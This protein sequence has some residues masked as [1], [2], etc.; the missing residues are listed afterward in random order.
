MHALLEL[1][2]QTSLVLFYSPFL[3]KNV[4]LLKAANNVMASIFYSKNY[5]KLTGRS[6]RARG[7]KVLLLDLEYT[8]DTAILFANCEDLTNGVNRIVT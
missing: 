2:K 5:V 1:S 4:F 8:D 3:L 6:Y 7:E